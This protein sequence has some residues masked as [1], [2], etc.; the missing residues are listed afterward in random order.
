MMCEKIYSM[1]KYCSGNL[2]RRHPGDQLKE[3]TYKDYLSYQM[4]YKAKQSD[5]K[6]AEK[7]RIFV[8]RGAGL[9]RFSL[10]YI[11]CSISC[12]NGTKNGRMNVEECEEVT[13]K[14]FCV[15]SQD[16]VR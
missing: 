11:H 10:H 15:K 13:K 6:F 3:P 5:W 16:I 14:Q 7:M 2:I 8:L 1:L 12:N 4:A 9:A